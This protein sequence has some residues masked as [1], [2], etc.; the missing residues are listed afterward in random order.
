MQRFLLVGATA[1]VILSGLA[2][3]V[4]PAKQELATLRTELPAALRRLY[5]LTPRGA[6]VRNQQDKW[7]QENSAAIWNS[8]P[9]PDS[10][11]A[12]QARTN[13][14]ITWIEKT[15]IMLSRRFTLNDIAQQC[16]SVPPPGD[17]ETKADCRVE[18]FG[19]IDGRSDL[20]YQI[21]R[22]LSQSDPIG[23]FSAGDLQ[24]TT[25]ALFSHPR[26]EDE[27]EI[28]G[29][30]DTYAQKPYVTTWRNSSTLLVLPD[31]QHGSGG[32][33]HDHAYVLEQPENIWHEIDVNKWEEDIEARLPSGLTPS[34]GHSVDY[35]Q[36]IG[37]VF[38]AHNTDPHC[39]PSGGRAVARLTIRDRRL[40]IDDLQIVGGTPSFTGPGGILTS[41]SRR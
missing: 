24:A 3:A 33:V 34:R 32:Y 1:M 30:T 35:N 38:L 11:A 6:E 5:Q 20:R 39:C 26:K 25:V 8:D 4:E 7:Q 17:M 41:P 13:Q 14:I 36:G 12:L 37:Q 28:I 23:V 21:H 16:I 9:K 2:G 22:D 10:I 27:F 29:W 19:R 31:F 15:Q 40:A 18:E